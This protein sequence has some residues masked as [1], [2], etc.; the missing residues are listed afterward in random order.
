MNSNEKAQQALET[1][2]GAQVDASSFGPEV[3]ADTDLAPAQFLGEPDDHLRGLDFYS[4]PSALSAVQRALTAK[5]QDF[6]RLMDKHNALHMA[7]QR[8]RDRVTELELLTGHQAPAVP[9][10]PNGFAPFDMPFSEARKTILAM[11]LD[12]A[13]GLA[14]SLLIQNGL[15]QKYAAPA[16]VPKRVDAWSYEWHGDADEGSTRWHKRLSED[17]PTEGLPAN[18]MKNYR[19]IRAMIFADGLPIESPSSS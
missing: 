18:Q 14:I 8:C 17:H 19:N 10:V 3:D 2:S 5:Q 15:M 12:D 1:A 13:R 11:G 7:A 6:Q 4:Y 9:N 16:G